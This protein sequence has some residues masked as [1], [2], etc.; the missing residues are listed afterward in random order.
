MA[1]SMRAGSL[2]LL[3]TGLL[4]CPSAAQE[5]PDPSE[6]EKRFWENRRLQKAAAACEIAL[7][8]TPLGKFTIVGLAPHL[9]VFSEVDFVPAA[10]PDLNRD[11]FPWIRDDTPQPDI[12]QYAP[13]KIPK[14]KLA[15]VLAH[16]Q[17]LL[18]SSV[19]P[20][21]KFKERAEEN[22]YVTV[23]HL[24]NEAKRY[25][26]KIIPIKGRLMRLRKWETGEDLKKQGIPYT[27]EGWIMGPTKGFNP[28]WVVFVHLPQGLEPSEEMDREVE[29]YGYFL[30]RIKYPAGDKERTTAILIGPTLIVKGTPKAVD[31]VSPLSFPLTVLMFVVGGLIFMGVLIFGFSWWFRRTDL[32]NRVQ[33][34]RIREN[35]RRAIEEDLPWMRSTALDKT[36]EQDTNMD[37]MKS[38][39]PTEEHEGPPKNLP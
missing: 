13:D 21:E 36:T 22:D 20:V 11:W 12:T 28:F 24:W 10:A 5:Q 18:Y 2:M 39:D 6:S 29:F 38:E 4:A 30:K 1:L 31:V 33:I 9:H 37:V 32:R 26:G 14:D 34:E 19:V 8:P 35:Q 16:N 17:A 3:L 7:M 27:Y 23:A 25:R 15:Y